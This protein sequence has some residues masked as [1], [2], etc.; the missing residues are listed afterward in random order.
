MSLAAAISEAARAS[1]IPEQALTL[2]VAM[3][4]PT[5]SKMGGR[6]GISP[7]QAQEIRQK[8]QEIALKKEVI[9]GRVC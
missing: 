5:L 9:H 8:A 6:L 2:A 1:H 7:Y 3:L 4:W